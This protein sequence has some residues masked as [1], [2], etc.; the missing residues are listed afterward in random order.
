MRH[1]AAVLLR[2]RRNV[3][4]D[5][6]TSGPTQI[7]VHVDKFTYDVRNSLY[8]VAQYQVQSIVANNQTAQLTFESIDEIC[9]HLIIKK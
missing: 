8:F 6:N 7:V 9:R 4:H 2:F 3:P 5:R 1:S